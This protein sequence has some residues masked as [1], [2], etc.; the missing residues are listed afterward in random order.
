MSIVTALRALLWGVISAGLLAAMGSP[1]A[2]ARRPAPI[3]GRRSA[4]SQKGYG[5]VR[6]G[7][8]FNGG[9]P[10]GLVQDVH[11]G[12]W[13]AG[14]AIGHGTGDFVWPGQSVARGSLSASATVVAYD[15]GTC[16]GRL[17]YRKIQWYFPAYG[18]SF[19]ADHSQ[20]ICGSSYPRY[21]PPAKCGEV[22]FKSGG[23]LASA[24]EAEGITC[25]KALELVATSPAMQYLSGG[26]RFIDAGLYCG[27]EGQLPETSPT[28]FQ[29]TRGP[30]NILFQVSG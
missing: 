23:G 9:D 4:P 1:V 19:E 2:Q 20:D 5:E 30:V 15:L 14:E 25:P 8:I 22:S 28:L 18:E 11:W 17:A 29:C 16:R 27:T 26:G 6:P 7:T 24:V 13:G 12:H 3:L 21:V 10:T